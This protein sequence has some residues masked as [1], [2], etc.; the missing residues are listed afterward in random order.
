MIVVLSGKAGSGKSTVAE[1]LERAHGFTSLAFADPLKVAAQA[2]FGFE[3]LSLWGASEFRGA[4]DPWNPKPNGEGLSPREAL[5]ALGRTVNACSPGALIRTAV[6]DAM[7]SQKMRADVV[8]TDARFV[9]ELEAFR[10]LGAFFL[11]V[12]RPGAGLAGEAG[13]SEYETSLDQIPDA[14]FD[15]LL[16]NAGTREALLAAVDALVPRLRA[17]L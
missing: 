10:P 9:D 5:A 7:V 6:R 1:H 17:G 16:Q 15:V 4:P 2:I 11:R 12:V 14:A 13:R 8:V 3:K